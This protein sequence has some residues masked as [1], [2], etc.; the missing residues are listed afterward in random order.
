MRPLALRRI[1]LR[2][3]D[4]DAARRFYAG[5]WGL[6]ELAETAERTDVAALRATG[7]E[8]HVLQLRRAAPGA[9]NG[10]DH[11][12]FAVATPADVDRWAE[13]LA[14]HGV[15]LVADPGPLPGPGGGYGLRLRDPERRVVELSAEVE[16]VPP[17]PAEPS[18]P[19]KLAHVVL[20]TTE[21]DAACAWWCDVLGLRV[22]DWSEHQM[23]FLRT[24][25]D[26]H[27]IAFNQ[28]E[29]ASLNHVAYEVGS[30]D[31]FMRAQ[32][33][34]RHHGTTP[35]WGPGRHGPG[36]N[37]FAYFVDPAGLVCEY[38]AEVAQVDEATWQPRVW[39]RVPELSD[40]W[41][42]AGPPSPDV[43]RH[44][45][46]RPDPGPDP[47]P[48][49]DPDPAP[50]GSATR[51]DPAADPGPTAGLAADLRPGPGTAP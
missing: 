14:A 31:G 16:A 19:H 43:R 3:E 29:W 36:N 1:G 12:A 20:N 4:F 32:G 27:V 5:P 51:P 37:T 18:R 46:G 15:P 40:L 42:T 48:A 28:G 22:S 23:V 7:P 13:R 26:H 6:E 33:R 35:A 24:N 38:T 44:M 2:V 30:L 9:G 50:A 34:L 47:D 39:R 25:A 17:R 11:I 21:I 49:S 10:I 41:G 45:A 8:H